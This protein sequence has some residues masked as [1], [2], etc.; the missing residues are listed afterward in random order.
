M[1]LSSLLA[2]CL[3]QLLLLKPHP[4]GHA[5]NL[6]PLTPTTVFSGLT[7]SGPLF[8]WTLTHHTYSDGRMG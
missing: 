4:L 5:L 2:A 1:A 6:D 7:S 8:G 3:L